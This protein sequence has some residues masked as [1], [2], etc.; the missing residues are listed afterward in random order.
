MEPRAVNEFFLGLDG[1][2]TQTRW[3]V[4]DAAGEVRASGAVGAMATLRL[5][6]TD[7]LADARGL[8]QSLALEIG[9]WPLTA[10]LAGM[11]GIGTPE[12][13]AAQTL[14]HLMGQSL[15]VL[16]QRVQVT[17][18]IALA[19]AGA[20][21]PGQGYLIYAGTGSV[22]AFV[23]SE[24][25]LHRAGGRGGIL[26]DG[27]SGY[28]IGREALRHIWRTEDEQPLAWQA[29]AMA[30]KVF[31]RIGG[32]D[33]AHTRALVYAGS[34]GAMGEVALAVADAAAQDSVAL[35]ILRQAGTELG[36]LGQAMV[37]RF[38]PRPMALGGRVSLLHPEIA[39]SLRQA[40]APGQALQIVQTEGHVVAAQWCGR[41]FGKL[42]V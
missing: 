40:L 35:S 32:S 10:V 7:A 24:G 21:A 18:D 15:G 4:C 16:P 28:W 23:D 5:G 17:S 30:Q 6:Q 36:R 41:T 22:A 20:F 2:G 37:R 27:G 3:A 42:A 34:R 29:S 14:R 33:W 31:A 26:D 19:Y 1:G 39:N 25:H 9:A 13:E 38:G 12:D 11:S 8:L